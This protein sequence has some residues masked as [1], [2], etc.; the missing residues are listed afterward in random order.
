MQKPG[1][2][3][4][5]AGVAVLAVVA[6]VFAFKGAS[7]SEIRDLAKRGSDESAM[8]AAVEKSKQPYKLSADDIISLKRD[9]V[10]D[11]VVV[12][13]IEHKP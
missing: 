1:L 12:K 8:I 11:K 10:P 13:M 2:I 5:I 4:G 6:M 7:T 9:G 3:L